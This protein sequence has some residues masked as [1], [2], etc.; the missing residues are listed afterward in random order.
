MFPGTYD[1]CIICGGTHQQLSYA[2]C[3][4]YQNPITKKWEAS[5]NGSI[6]KLKP[7]IVPPKPKSDKKIAMG[8]Y[9]EKYKLSKAFGS[10]T[11]PH[12]KLGKWSGNILPDNESSKLWHTLD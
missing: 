12:I 3:P 4:V 8:K 9:K 7:I 5:I 10:F 2:N 6:V 11:P 1:N